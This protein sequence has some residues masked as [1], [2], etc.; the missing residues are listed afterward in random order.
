MYQKL[1]GDLEIYTQEAYDLLDWAPCK[2]FV[3][4]IHDAI[5]YSES[6]E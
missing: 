1:F 5:L 3:A 4:G 6:V 2:T